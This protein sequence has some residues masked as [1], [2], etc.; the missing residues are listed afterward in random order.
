[1]LPTH[2]KAAKELLER[3]Y[4]KIAAELF[5]ATEL[6]IAHENT[7]PLARYRPVMGREGRSV[8]EFGNDLKRYHDDYVII[9]SIIPREERPDLDQYLAVTTALSL[10]NEMAHFE[11]DRAGSLKDFF[12][13]RKKGDQ[14]RVCALYALQQH[15]SDVV[16][17]NFAVTLDRMFLSENKPK[18]RLAIRSSLEKMNL[19]QF[20]PSYEDAYLRRDTASLDAVLA[21]IKRSRM[22][23]NMSGLP[24][25]RAGG[26]VVLG[27]DVIQRAVTGTGFAFPQKLLRIPPLPPLPSARYNG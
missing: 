27:Q 16:M 24:G 9:T 15:A 11:Q 1:M 23:L 5:A 12:S 13:F 2:I 20:F 10:A 17:L 26:E 8:I 25:C 14:D 22:A 21:Q 6:K 3:A 4:P 7:A 18:G 19:A